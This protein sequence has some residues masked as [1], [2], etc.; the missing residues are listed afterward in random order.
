M[1]PPNETPAQPGTASHGRAASAQGA[2]V[3]GYRK[4]RAPRGFTGPVALGFGSLAL[5]VL[6]FGSWAIMTQIAGAVIAGGKVEVSSRQQVVQHPDGG[7]VEKIHVAEGDKVAAG[8]LL[9]TLDGTFLRS[10]LSI[11]EGQFFEL[12]A[13]SGRLEA[14]RDES[15]EIV[16]PEEL[17]AR[18][19]TDPT[20]Q[21][22]IQGQRRLFEARAATLRQN[23]AQLTERKAQITSQIG[24]IGAQLEALDEQLDL[25]RRELADQNSLLE[26]GLTQASRVLALQREAAQL[27]GQI[28]S[29]RAS[30]AEAEGKITE[31]D[32]EILRLGST[33]QEE[34][35]TEL[36]DLG[37]RELELAERRRSLSEQINRLELR[38][39][40]SGIVH[41]LQVTTPRAVVR[42]AEPV[43]HLVPQDL[44]FVITALIRP[45]DINHIHPGREAALRFPAFNS[46]TTPELIGHIQ[47]VSADTFEDEQSGTSYY[48]AEITLDEG[49]AE[50]L[51]GDGL[52]PGMPVEAMISTSARTPMSYLVKPLADYFMKAFREE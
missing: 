51:G 15:T 30:R 20:T 31:T 50:L 34:A 29:L 37:Y 49:Q 35:V 1:I 4:D 3:K 40:V 33:R 7:V 8:D 12:L 39:P 13:R 5:L 47:R 14:E 26:R 6:V 9:L 42:A 18:A 24:G 16:F 46:R 23:R 44:P 32:I 45:T 28:G 25:I 36:R 48:R 2:Q 43:A 10:E 41:G 52:L 11:V 21:T 22:L 27:Q 19:S 17:T 38:A